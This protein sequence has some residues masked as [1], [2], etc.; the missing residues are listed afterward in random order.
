MRHQP[1]GIYSRNNYHFW[2]KTGERGGA[3][4]AS[5]SANTFSTPSLLT[6]LPSHFNWGVII[7]KEQTKYQRPAGRS[8]RGWGEQSKSEPRLGGRSQH[9]AQTSPIPVKTQCPKPNRS[10]RKF[11]KPEPKA[12]ATA[13]SVLQACAEIQAA[14]PD[15][16]A[17]AKS[18]QDTFLPAISWHFICSSLIDR[19]KTRPSAMADSWDTVSSSFVSNILTGWISSLKDTKQVLHLGS[20]FSWL[21]AL[22][23]TFSP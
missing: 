20:H 8:W 15:C 7:C 10:C 18:E 23:V 19:S 6:H 3:H 21:C 17:Y 16:M 12:S 14:T 9:A 4:S 11:T 13:T 5:S 22:V 2:S 1:N